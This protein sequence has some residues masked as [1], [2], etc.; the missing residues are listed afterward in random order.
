MFGMLNG[1]EIVLLLFMAPV[2]LAPAGIA[3]V[4]K[5]RNALAIGLLNVLLGWT[6]IGWILALIW[7]VYRERESR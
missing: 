3:I 1:W 7:A 4:R 2:Y 5:H 6:V